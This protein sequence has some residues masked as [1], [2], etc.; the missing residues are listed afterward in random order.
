MAPSPTNDLTTQRFTRFPAGLLATLGLNDTHIHDEYES[1]G[2]GSCSMTVHTRRALIELHIHAR[3]TSATLT[4]TSNAPRSDMS[5]KTPSLTTAVHLD[6]ALIGSLRA[7]MW[8]ERDPS[9]GALDLGRITANDPVATLS[10]TLLDKL[11][12]GDSVRDLYVRSLGLSIAAR[13]LS[14]DRRDRDGQQ[15]RGVS[16]L[17]KWRVKRVSEYVDANLSRKIT[18][19]AMAAIAGLTPMYFAAQF[20]AAMNMRP[21]DF[22]L[23]RRIAYAQDRLANSSD[24][25]VD[26]ALDSGFRTQAHFTTVFGKFVGETPHRWREIAQGRRI[27]A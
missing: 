8:H 24:R 17:P 21:H 23:K 27:S 16:P 9:H 2:I 10:S 19:A 1:H 25:L 5:N 12:G 26:I 22:V 7:A 13:V 3:S 20:R 6:D 11:E 14:S 15:A 4:L 18:L